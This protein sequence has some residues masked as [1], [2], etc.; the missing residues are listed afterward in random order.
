[1]EQQDQKPEKNLGNRGK[2]RAKGSRNKTTTMLKE[3]ILRAASD[4]GGD[5][6]LVGY[7]TAQATENP[8]PFLAL[9]GKVL[10]LQVNGSGE[11]GEHQIIFKTVYEAE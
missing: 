11:N 2:G 7:L 10:P 3:A 9:L 8:G 4:A 1:M 6:G 5:E